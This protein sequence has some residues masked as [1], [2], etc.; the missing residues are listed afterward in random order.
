M[1]IGGSIE[2]V[3]LAGRVFS[4]ASDADTQR[5]LGGYENEVQMNGD[6]T[7]RMIKT[8]VA[9]QITGLQLSIND[10][11]GDDEFITE[12]KNGLDFFPA[13]VTYASG[14]SYSGKLQIVGEHVYNSQAG[15]ATVDLHGPGALTRI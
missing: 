5:K 9:A 15:T 13:V 14:V 8:R 4:V 12:L 3:S 11:R 7:G 10:E 2:S 6:G 1:A